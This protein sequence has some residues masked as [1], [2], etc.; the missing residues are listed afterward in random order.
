MQ[1]KILEHVVKWDG[2]KISFLLGIFL[3][4]FLAASMRVEGKELSDNVKLIRGEHS[5]IPAD[6]IT[7]DSEYC[8]ITIVS[9]KP[10]YYSYLSFGAKKYVIKASKLKKA[11][12]ID[13][14]YVIDYSACKPKSS[15]C[16]GIGSDNCDYTV[17][18][19]SWEYRDQEKYYASNGKEKTWNGNKYYTCLGST[20]DYLYQ[21][22]AYY[23]SE[24][25][26]VSS[27]KWDANRGD[28]ICGTDLIMSA[29]IKE[30]GDKEEGGINEVGLYSVRSYGNGEHSVFHRENINKKWSY[31]YPFFKYWNSPHVEYQSSFPYDFIWK[32]TEE[33]TWNTSSSFTGKKLKEYLSTGAKLQIRFAIVHDLHT[34][35]DREVIS[36][37]WG[38]FDRYDMPVNVKLSKAKVAK[39]P[40]IRIDAVK[41]TINLANGMQYSFDGM[42]WKTIYPYT[43]KFGVESGWWSNYDTC[44]CCYKDYYKQLES[45]DERE[46]CPS[47][48]NQLPPFDN[49]KYSKVCLRSL[50]LC[51]DEANARSFFGRDYYYYHYHYI[52][53]DNI[54]SEVLFSRCDDSYVGWLPGIADKIYVRKLAAGNGLP[55]EIATVVLPDGG[56]SGR[57]QVSLAA[58]SGGMKVQKIQ[59]DEWD[60]VKNPVFEYGISEDWFFEDADGD[61]QYDLLDKYMKEKYGSEVEYDTDTNY[62]N[63]S[64]GIV[65]ANC[66]AGQVIKTVKYKIKVSL[67][68]YVDKQ[69]KQHDFSHSIPNGCKYVDVTVPISV[70]PGK[71][72]IY[73]RRKA[74]SSKDTSDIVW[75]S[76]ISE[77][78]QATSAKH[79]D[80]NVTVES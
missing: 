64:Y 41:E 27:I 10:V 52:N 53:H 13:G 22:D 21:I 49:F 80:K 15:Y 72:R 40:K 77:Y 30:N 6:K 74:V 46:K 60:E 58:V 73:F 71:T 67:W 7:V 24:M 56:R 65:W 32:E 70:V 34:S 9:D 42:H 33:K 55:S 62:P 39:A 11:E 35:K 66:K 1:K 19:F 45:H 23:A 25:E 76:Y 31:T 44:S 29:S 63:G 5:G 16:I 61:G 50:I 28:T 47:D 17:N 75:S 48:G 51:K 14:K 69:G 26:T 59:A 2:W 38:K 78:R 18:G 4:S 54:R 68:S 36:K 79:A 37:K 43:L 8:L 12:L 20:F 3:C 57:P